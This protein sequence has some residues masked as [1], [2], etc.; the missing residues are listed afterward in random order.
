[1]GGLIGLVAAGPIGVVAGVLLGT[2]FDAKL[3]S[4][5]LRDAPRASTAIQKAFFRA[6]FQVMGHLAKADGRVSEQEIR[7]ARGMM[8]ELQLGE[9]ETQ[10]A[11]DLYREGKSSAF[12]IRETLVELARL[13]ADRKDLCRMFVL[14]QLQ[15]ALAGDGLNAAG[16][17]VMATIASTLR[18]PAFEVIQMEALLRMR[19]AASRQT[20]AGDPLAAAYEVLGVTPTA[21]DREITKAYR[22][23]MNRHH[24]DKL[25]A[26]GMPPS[27][28]HAAEEKTRQIRAAYDA[29]REARGMK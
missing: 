20:S 11:M 18:V 12:P 5:E 19:R 7:A 17:R 21:S 14:I 22:R 23:L 3:S 13:C 1:M 29:I 28:M 9:A 25:A 15:T 6:T 24:P 26:K 2:L 16:R 4:K 10:T 27:A 8:E